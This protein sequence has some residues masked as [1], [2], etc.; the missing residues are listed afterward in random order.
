MNVDHNTI[1]IIDWPS[2]P[3]GGARLRGTLLTTAMSINPRPTAC[4]T[5]QRPDIKFGE[6]V[7][8]RWAPLLAAGQTIKGKWGRHW[9][10]VRLAETT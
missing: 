5:P 4:P 8:R 9:Y 3:C 2:A 7:A 6:A 10:K 1:V